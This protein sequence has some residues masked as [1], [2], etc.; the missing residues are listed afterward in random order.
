MQHDDNLVGP[1]G[2][3]P[4]LN[5]ECREVLKSQEF[6]N[7]PVM[8]KLLAFLTDQTVL[9]N[10]GTLKSYGVAIDGLGRSPDFDPATDSYPRVQVGRLRK[11][12]AAYYA[13]RPNHRANC[14]FIPQGSYEVRLLT[15][16][17]AYPPLAPV[18]LI[19]TIE[20]TPRSATVIAQ[21][22]TAES[23]RRPRWSDWRVQCLSLAMAM[24]FAIVAVALLR[25]PQQAQAQAQS[26]DA[27]R[28]SIAI[29]VS[30]VSSNEPTPTLKLVNAQLIDGI[31]RFAII[32]IL[33]G[34][35]GKNADYKVEALVQ[36]GTARSKNLYVSLYDNRKHTLLWTRT[37]P[38]SS[39]NEETERALGPAITRIAGFF[40][41]VAERERAK[42]RG[43]I[44]SSYSCILAF[45]KYFRTRDQSMRPAVASCVQK[46]STDSALQPGI[47]TSRALMLYDGA[48]DPKDRPAALRE[49]KLLIEDANSIA[50]RDVHSRFGRAA[51]ALYSGQCGAGM[52]AADHMV[53]TNPYAA[54][55][56]RIIGMILQPCDEAAGHKLLVEAQRLELEGPLIVRLPTVMD[57]FKRHDRVALVKAMEV[58]DRDGAARG[59]YEALLKAVTYARMGDYKS[60]R[61]NYARFQK[62]TPGT[63]RGL[64]DLVRIH[65]LSDYVRADIVRDLKAAGIR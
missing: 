23:Q 8:A 34:R 14:L 11:M 12:L 13:R 50:V 27:G 9:G 20:P 21:L 22:V 39:E 30:D 24:V 60:A 2:F 64:D 48:V 18:E 54:E 29:E 15:Q 56:Q 6:E 5:R 43:K 28:P 26:S 45:H 33:D 3:G 49:A 61:T 59:S 10:G 58:T 57:A 41:V 53:R 62:L 31:S 25:T 36:S 38:V 35:A 19:E 16:S 1:A 63:R 46:D 51:I 42:Q 32:E 40:G 44:T 7:S 55:L 47:L 17:E 52:E 4:E 37:Y 65:V